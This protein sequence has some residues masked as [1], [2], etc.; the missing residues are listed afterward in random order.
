MYELVIKYLSTQYW[1]D[2]YSDT[3]YDSQVK[4]YG[5]QLR[6]DIVDMFDVSD[7]IAT[8]C[9]EI[10]LYDES[11]TFDTNKFWEDIINP[12]N[13]GNGGI[14]GSIDLEYM[15]NI[16]ESQRQIGRLMG[17]SSEMFGESL[18]QLGDTTSRTELAL[19][20]WRNV[21]IKYPVETI[22]IIPTILP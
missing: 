19:N 6:N 2:S 14:R 4:V 1:V 16:A 12:W 5:E 10:W 17:V 9:I 22:N 15:N 3:V 7:V 20:N 21:S 11:V 8:A 18:Q 13:I